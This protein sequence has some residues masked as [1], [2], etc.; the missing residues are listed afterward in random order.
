[1]VRLV[2]IAGWLCHGCVIVWVIGVIP[3]VVGVDGVAG[4]GGVWYIKG[5]G[6]NT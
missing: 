1:M 3:V 4:E 5:D 6:G 2:S